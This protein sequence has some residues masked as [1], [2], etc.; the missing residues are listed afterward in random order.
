M[1]CL[2]L[3]T[4]WADHPSCRHVINPD[5]L[6]S[7][8]TYPGLHHILFVYLGDTVAD[9]DKNPFSILF[10][11]LNTFLKGRKS[12]KKSYIWYTFHKDPNKVM[13]QKREVVYD[14]KP[15]ENQFK[16]GICKRKEVWVSKDIKPNTR[17]LFRAKQDLKYSESLLGNF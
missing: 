11:S 8:V 5:V 7:A 3:H 17:F 4:G 1:N 12:I 9:S 10:Q 6:P 2:S 16:G 14:Y 15:K 13:I